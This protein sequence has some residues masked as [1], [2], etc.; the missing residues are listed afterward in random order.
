MVTDMSILIAYDG[1]Q[2]TEAALEYATKLS[3]SLEEPLYILNVVSKEQ[4]DPED[5]DP[6]VQE[7][8]A[9]ASQKAMAAGADVHTIIEVGKP[10]DVILEVATNFQ[11][12]AVVVGRPERSRLDRMVMG[13]VSQNLVENC[14]C[15]V[16]IVPT[17]EE[18]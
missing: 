9:A 4:M 3:V 10:D 13:S 6:T 7:Y 11:C 5:I 2:A 8:M 14:K 18:E 15:P 17:P 1:R 16:I 12:G